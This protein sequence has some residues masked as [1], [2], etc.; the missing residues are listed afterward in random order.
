[1]D[2]SKPNNQHNNFGATQEQELPKTAS[3]DNDEKEQEDIGEP[4][5]IEEMKLKHQLYGVQR[6]QQQ[7]QQVLLQHNFQFLLNNHHNT[8]TSFNSN[9]NNNNNFTSIQQG[10]FSSPYLQTNNNMM[11][12]MPSDN[13]TQA[14]LSQRPFNPLATTVRIQQQQQQQQQLHYQQQPQHH[15]IMNNSVQNSIHQLQQLEYQKQQLEFQLQHQQQQQQ[16]LQ[17]QQL[18]FQLHQQ[19]QHMAMLSWSQP[20]VTATSSS[21]GSNNAVI[22]NAATVAAP[23]NVMSQ[24]QPPAQP[25]Q[26]LA[27][28]LPTAASTK[29]TIDPSLITTTTTTTTMMQGQQ[30]QQQQQ[31]QDY[32]ATTAGIDGNVNG[33]DSTNNNPMLFVPIPALSSST[34]AGAPATIAKLPSSSSTD[35]ITTATTH[36][37]LPNQSYLGGI[38][39]LG[40]IPHPNI[41]SSLVSAA[42]QSTS[43]FG[44][45]PPAYQTID[46]TSQVRIPSAS[47]S[48]TTQSTIRTGLLPKLVNP[49]GNTPVSF[50]NFRS[51][52]SPRVASSGLGKKQQKEQE[53]EDPK[54]NNSASSSAVVRPLSAYNYFFTEEREKMLHGEGKYGDESHEER[55]ARLL[56]MHLSKDRNKRRPHRKTHGKISF[57]T[58]SKQI[59][60]RWRQLTN[61][62][63]DFYKSVAAADVARYK[64]ES[65]ILEEKDKLFR[66]RDEK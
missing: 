3:G 30:Q 50:S 16:Q 40:K 12:M 46:P 28:M 19:Q 29:R 2:D 59:G 17:R 10:L 39:H 55:K 49:V 61:E 62:E 48:S 47:P 42:D 52:S 58:L 25:P 65:F 64:E 44:S 33:M 8:S 31:Q 13:N 34:V 43:L 63:K 5:S 57:T 51:P 1:M 37:Q 56:S 38:P 35:N 53:K 18:E 14:M 15:N 41:T 6:Q 26:Q 54:S 24:H 45:S 23:T 11:M 22:P 4:I 20:G 32:H 60:Q 9:N 36:C 66:G 7:Q 27:S 21:F